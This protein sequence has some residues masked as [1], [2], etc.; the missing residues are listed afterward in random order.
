MTQ[1]QWLAQGTPGERMD[2]GIVRGHPLLLS[3]LSEWGLSQA[4]RVVLGGGWLREVNNH[5]TLRASA[6]ASQGLN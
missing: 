1:Q 3:R 6:G 2:L 4:F 5:L